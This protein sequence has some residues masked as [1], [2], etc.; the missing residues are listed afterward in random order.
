MTQTKNNSTS[1][2]DSSPSII[3]F[4][5]YVMA[6]LSAVFGPLGAFWI[7]LSGATGENPNLASAWM[8]GLGIL[9]LGFGAGTLFWGMG[10]I[11]R[12]RHLTLAVQKK[13]LQQ[14]SVT[15]AS[16]SASQPPLPS[17]ISALGAGAPAMNHQQTELL[18]R[19]LDQLGQLSTNVLLPAEQRT[20][21]YHQL[22]ENIIDELSQQITQAIED[23][24]LDAAE[25]LTKRLADYADKSLVEVFQEKI[26]TSR[27]KK[28]LLL[29]EGHSQRVTDLMAVSKFDEAIGLAQKLKDKFPAAPEAKSLLQRVKYEAETYTKEQCT[30]LYAEVQSA[31][32]ARQWTAALAAAHKL[33]EE[34]PDSSQAEKTRVMMPTI[35]DNTRIEEVREIRNRILDMMERRRYSEALELANQVIENYPETAAAEELRGQIAH[36]QQLIQASQK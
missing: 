5:L 7:I 35:V 14:L 26:A 27:K 25:T 21:K 23:E 29:V 12:Q 30:R 1:Q 11:I 2:Q 19:I 3:I 16:D 13:L 10:W 28:L 18:N 4:G 36:L 20:Q 34:F 17:N 31:G 33:M 15:S 9:L 24:Q 8:S 6:G 22:R 32:E